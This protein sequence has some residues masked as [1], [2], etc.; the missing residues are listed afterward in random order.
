MT[1]GSTL[2]RISGVYHG[3]DTIGGAGLPTRDTAPYE[4][5]YTCCGASSLESSHV[6][7]R[8]ASQPGALHQIKICR[9]PR[10]LEAEACGSGR[11]GPQGLGANRN[12]V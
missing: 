2:T 6:S 10:Q 12:Y 3:G 5:M 9:H 8:I 7:D 4:Y 11:S 1:V